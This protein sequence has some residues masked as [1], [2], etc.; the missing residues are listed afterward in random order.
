MTCVAGG[1]FYRVRAACSFLQVPDR[2][3]VAVPY[4][5]PVLCGLVDI[6]VPVVHVNSC[7]ARG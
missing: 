1:V 5:C 7:I 3:V 6:G 4:P 2:L